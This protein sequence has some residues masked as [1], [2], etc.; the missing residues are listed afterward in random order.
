MRWY[1]LHVA[2]CTEA[3]VTR[4]LGESGVEA[5]Y[6]FVLQK[7]KR[8]YRPDV[9][10][11]LMPGYVFAKFN[12]AERGL[13]FQTP[14]IIQILGCAGHAVAI[15]DSEIQTVRLLVDNFA[16]AS[17]TICPFMVAG[18]AVTITRGPFE[19]SSGY[20]SYVRGQARLVVSVQLLHQSISVEIDSADAELV[21]PKAA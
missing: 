20:I 16:N 2:S 6:P 15:P 3:I 21:L 5:F 1:A 7:S 9:E 12:L 17:L 8:L 4:K 14:Q 19:G 11:K 10:K 18:E 13:V